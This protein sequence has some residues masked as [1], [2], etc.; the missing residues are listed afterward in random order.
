M[1]RRNLMNQLVVGVWT[2]LAMTL[3]YAATPLWTYSAPSPAATTISAGSIATIQYTVTNQSTKSKDLILQLTPGLSASSCR[4][5]TKGSTCVLTLTVNGS[6][7]LQEGIHTGPILCEQGNPLQCYQPSQA[8]SLNIN[9]IKNF[10][11]TLSVNSTGTIPVDGSTPCT[12]DP[13]SLT[14]TNTGTYTAFN[15]SA[16]LP[17]GWAGV[18]Q[19]AT[20]TDCAPGATSCTSIAPNDTCTLNFT[21]TT[22]YVAEGNIS[23]T[24]DN[25]STPPTTALAFTMDCYLVWAASG[26]TGQVIQTN[27]ATGSPMNWSQNLINIPGIT[28]TSTTAGMDA[29]NGATDGNC[30]TGQIVGHYGTPYTNYAAG[31]C[32]GISSDNSGTVSAGTWYLPA[33]CQM[34]GSGQGAGCSSGL[35]N[36]DTNLV[37]LGFSGLSG[38]YWSSTEFSNSPLIGAWAEYFASGGG[39]NQS[40]INKMNQF[41]VR[42]SRTLTL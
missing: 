18:T 33:I 35:A 15:V 19:N 9:L 34:G 30:D 39:S 25:I 11:T 5:A 4:L 7:L 17:G 41:G 26:P 6:A 3:A 40:A 31:L 24:G 8:N 32:Y 42:C 16:S 1:K 27:D 13:I 28:E 36:I 2:M 22:P 14:V 37:Q 29:C 38:Y 21:S 23:I 10:N 12:P 20:C